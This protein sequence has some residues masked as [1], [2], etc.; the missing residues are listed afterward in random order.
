MWWIAPDETSSIWQLVMSGEGY[1]SWDQL[2]ASDA[3][4][5][6]QGYTAFHD[7]MQHA[8]LSGERK[9]SGVGGI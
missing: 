7:A 2:V 5:G 3:Q 1:G 6:G 9:V 8:V 4:I